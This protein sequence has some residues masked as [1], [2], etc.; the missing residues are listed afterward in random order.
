MKGLLEGKN[1]NKQTSFSSGNSVLPMKSMCS[2]AN[3]KTYLN[4]LTHNT[5]RRLQS[6]NR[7]NKKRTTNLENERGLVPPQDHRNCPFLHTLQ[8]LPVKYKISKSI[9]LV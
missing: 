9:F 8:Q 7:I 3:H 4:K 5:P 1:I 6:F 2:A